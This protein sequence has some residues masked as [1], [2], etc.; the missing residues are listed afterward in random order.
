MPFFTMTRPWLWHSMHEEQIRTPI[1]V[2]WSSKLKIGY[3]ALINT[4]TYFINELGVIFRIWGIGLQPHDKIIC[5]GY[6]LGNNMF[7]SLDN[8]ISINFT[9]NSSLLV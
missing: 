8:S 2:P 5:V 4:R 9:P 6:D 7:K 3:M 1:V